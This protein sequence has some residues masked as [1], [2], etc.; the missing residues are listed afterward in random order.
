MNLESCNNKPIISCEELCTLKNSE[1]LKDTA[2]SDC[3]DVVNIIGYR[4]IIS[5]YY[6]QQCS[7][8]FGYQATALI[9]SK[10][11]ELLVFW[12]QG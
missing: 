12:H 9:K 10:E 4:S 5:I 6:V 1:G 8:G 7:S 3:K 11:R 2:T